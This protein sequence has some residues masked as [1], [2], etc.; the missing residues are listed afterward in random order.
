MVKPFI[1]FFIL[2]VLLNHSSEVWNFINF[3][4]VLR[5]AGMCSLS[6]SP[7]T[8]GGGGSV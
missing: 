8:V 1:F 4:G 7:V 3:K 5:R 2:N 6:L